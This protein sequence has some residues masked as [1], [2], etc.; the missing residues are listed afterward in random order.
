MVALV[1]AGV[2]V[3]SAQTHQLGAD[4]GTIAIAQAD[5][6]SKSG[7]KSSV[8]KQRALVGARPP[9]L[10]DRRSAITAGR[11]S[12]ASERQRSGLFSGLWAWV[13]AQ[14]QKA[15]RSIVDAV[16]NLKS[17]GSLASA[18]ALIVLSFTYGVLHAAGPGHGKA[19]ISSYV[20]ANERTVRRGI[21]LSFLAAFF[22]ALSAIAIITVLVVVLKATSFQ[23]KGAEN[24]I[25]TLSW[26]LIA[27]LGAW[28]LIGQ[29]RILWQ[30][31]QA[32]DV[33]AAATCAHVQTHGHHDEGGACCDHAHIPDAKLLDHDWSWRKGV[34]IAASVGI[35][36]CTG[37]ILVLIFALTNGL[38]WAGI[39][40]TFAM[41]LGT[42]ITVSVLAAAAVGSRS[43]ATRMA[44]GDSRW[45]WRIERAAGL[46]GSALVFVLGASFFAA[47]LGPTAPF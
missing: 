24:W 25:T 3:A 28:L 4:V 39:A 1:L 15:N 8:V 10:T 46:V 16:R 11:N 14:Q 2:S 13:L 22:Q 44:G 29:L 5:A 26:G 37:A 35:R 20:L 47:S 12:P 9:A 32:R 23:I 19:V 6:A 40:A 36:P 18:L 30:A 33:A 34:M 38:L 31:W 17:S 21:A 41:A 42:A 45:G 43:L 7:D 27:A